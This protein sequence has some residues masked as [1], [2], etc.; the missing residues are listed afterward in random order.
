MQMKAMVSRSEVVS[1]G[2]LSALKTRSEN[3]HKKMEL[4]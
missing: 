3:R 4:G 2:Y 1:V